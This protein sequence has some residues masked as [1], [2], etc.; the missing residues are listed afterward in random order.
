MLA[1]ILNYRMFKKIKLLLVIF[2]SSLSVKAQNEVSL[3]EMNVNGI[4][5]ES[6]TIYDDG[7]YKLTS[8]YDLTFD[9]YGRYE[10]IEDYLFL[11]DENIYQNAVKLNNKLTPGTISNKVFKIEEDRIYIFE[12]GRIRKRIF[13][14]SMRKGLSN[15][16]G[17]K[18]LYLKNKN[19][20]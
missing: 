15:L 8:E 2:I 10:I 17:H 9:N 11:A 4:L 13:D 16:F 20:R 6:L 3:Y 19:F 7:T 18:Y 14:K 12:K 1:E 5:Y